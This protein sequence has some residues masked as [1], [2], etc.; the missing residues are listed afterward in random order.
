MSLPQIELAGCKLPGKE[1]HGKARLEK[2]SHFGVTRALRVVFR[3][4]TSPSATHSFFSAAA[5]FRYI[6]LN[7]YRDYCPSCSMGR[8]SFY[9]LNKSSVNANFLFT[10]P[11]RVQFLPHDHERAAR[12]RGDIFD[13]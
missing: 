12:D 2:K 3:W 8:K 4:F 11:I 1:G 9:N 6:E 5:K 10:M 13:S 7:V